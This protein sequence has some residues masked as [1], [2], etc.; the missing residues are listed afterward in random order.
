MLNVEIV[1][2][3]KAEETTFDE[4]FIAVYFNPSEG[5]S[6]TEVYESEP[7]AEDLGTEEGEILVSVLKVSKD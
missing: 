1:E 3:E 7:S 5:E 6:R 4:V 2:I